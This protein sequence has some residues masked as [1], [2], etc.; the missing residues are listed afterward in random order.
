MADFASGGRGTG[1]VSF[2]APCFARI[3]D[4]N[5]PHLLRQNLQGLLA[6]FFP[7]SL[8]QT[9]FIHCGEKHVDIKRILT[10]LYLGQEQ[11]F[12]R[13]PEFP[14]L[15]I[16]TINGKEEPRREVQ[17]EGRAPEKRSYK[18]GLD[19]EHITALGYILVATKVK[20]LIWEFKP[21]VASWFF[22]FNDPIMY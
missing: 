13:L 14:G 20:L 2:L 5:P 11:F 8:F 6:V 3:Q 15:E 18:P 22:P 12:S 17:L 7:N 19:C 10:F 1:T 9:S 4:S 21:S 16:Q